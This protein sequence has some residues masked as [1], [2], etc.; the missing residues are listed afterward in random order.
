VLLLVPD[1]LLFLEVLLLE[2]LL[3]I[4]AHVLGLLGVLHGLLRSRM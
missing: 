2:D 1:F 4:V 3:E